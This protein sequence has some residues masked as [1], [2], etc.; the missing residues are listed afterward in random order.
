MLREEV[1]ENLCYYDDRN[2]NWY[3]DWYDY[4]EEEIIKEKKEIEER[5]RCSC[6][7]CFYNRTNLAE[8]LLKYL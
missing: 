7:N 6:D 5:G 3:F 1:L 2:P 8:E 4:D